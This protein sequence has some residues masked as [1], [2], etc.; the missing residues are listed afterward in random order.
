MAATPG[1]AGPELQFVRRHRCIGASS[2]IYSIGV[3]V[4]QILACGE[5]EKTADPQYVKEMVMARYAEVMAYSQ[6]NDDAGNS[7]SAKT[8][9]K[10]IE[11]C[12]MRILP[13]PYDLC[14]DTQSLL[15]QMM[16]G[17]PEQ[18]PSAGEAAARLRSIAEK[19]WP[20]WT[21]QKFRLKASDWQDVFALSDF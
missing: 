13:F 14:Q 5:S 8:I 2:D 19:R 9:L 11:E 3:V 4:S 21:P 15:H 10:H 12:A 20:G 17:N 7:C 6:E 1:Y 18:R 16:D